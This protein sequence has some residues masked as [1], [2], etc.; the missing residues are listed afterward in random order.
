WLRPMN[1]SSLALPGC[2]SGPSGRSQTHGGQVD[3]TCVQHGPKHD[4][5]AH[6]GFV[7]GRMAPN[8]TPAGPDST[9]SWAAT[10][11][12]RKRLRTPGRIWHLRTFVRDGQRLHARLTSM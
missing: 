1:L 2:S 3:R 6:H 5:T 12:Y 8:Y 9:N 10:M 4:K 7:I 11:S